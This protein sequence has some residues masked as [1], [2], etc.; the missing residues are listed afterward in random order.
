MINF[1][2]DYRNYNKKEKKIIHKYCQ[3]YDLYN[4]YK[5]K[6]K[7][8]FYY[9]E[10]ADKYHNVICAN[11][12]FIIICSFNFFSNAEDIHKKCREILK[13][14]KKQENKYFIIYK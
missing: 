10:K 8:D 9:L 7:D 4:N 2:M 11:E 12:N 3:I 5:D 6:D 14:F 1:G 13:F